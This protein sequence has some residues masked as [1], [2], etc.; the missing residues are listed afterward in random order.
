LRRSSSPSS[1]ASRWSIYFDRGAEA[2][3]TQ[4][5]ATAL[6]P[7]ALVSSALTLSVAATLVVV[8]LALWKLRAD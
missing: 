6:V 2:G 5:A 1:A 7:L 4:E 3:P 8:A